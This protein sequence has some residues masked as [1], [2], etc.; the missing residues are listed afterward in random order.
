MGLAA[1]DQQD[2]E[3]AGSEVLAEVVRDEPNRGRIR[4]AVAA[5]RGYLAPAAA[6]AATGA[7]K[8]THE[9]AQHA[10]EQLG[11]SF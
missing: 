10:I 4:R 2:A 8:G 1:E 9:L 3:A 5:L 6:G 11:S 7:A